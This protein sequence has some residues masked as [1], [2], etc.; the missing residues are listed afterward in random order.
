MN[1]LCLV[2]PVDRYGEGIVVRITDAADRRFDPGLG[3]SLRI[4]NGHVLNSPVGAVH[5]AAAVGG[6][7]IMKRLLQGIDDEGDVDE[8]LP[9]GH[10]REVRN[11][12]PVRRRCLELAVHTVERTGGRLVRE[13]RLTGL[14]RMTP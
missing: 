7:P 8:A 6:T 14:P 11:P 2:K 5:K 12:E 4:T 13:R 1:D 10:L 3:Q 9:G